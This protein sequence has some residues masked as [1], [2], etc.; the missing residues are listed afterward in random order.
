MYICMFVLSVCPSQLMRY[1]C[2]QDIG[3]EVSNSRAVSVAIGRLVKGFHEPCKVYHTCQQGDW[4]RRVAQELL[5]D[6]SPLL[7]YK[8][9]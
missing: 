8:A 3:N 5:I 9:P 4:D 2:V 7:L 6:A 1:A